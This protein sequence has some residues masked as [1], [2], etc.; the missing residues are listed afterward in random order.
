MI[1]VELHEN[2][3]SRAKNAFM[4]VWMGGGKCQLSV[5]ILSF[6]QL[7]VRFWAICQLSVKC[8]LIIN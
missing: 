7:S 3:A 5:K 4:R 6:S 1:R 8:Q 2:E